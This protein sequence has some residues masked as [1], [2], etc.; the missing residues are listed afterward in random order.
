M[1]IFKP[2]ILY[3]KR[4]NVTGIRYF[5]KT[6]KIDKVYE[7]NGSGTYWK[8]HLKKHGYD[9]STEWVSE[10]FTDRELLEDFAL[11][12][13]E[14]FNI[15]GSDEWANLVSENGLD[16]GNRPKDYIFSAE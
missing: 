7:Y 15:V 8:Q 6:S 13:S 12:F 2:T 10:I 11:L 16:G 4:H 1:K 9:V 14:L 5:G 3:I